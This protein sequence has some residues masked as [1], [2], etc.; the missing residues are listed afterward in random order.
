MTIPLATCCLY[1]YSLL[2]TYHCRTA[3]TLFAI[4]SRELLKSR[5][6]YNQS[7]FRS[8]EIVWAKSV[9][10]PQ[11]PQNNCMLM[12]RGLPPSGLHPVLLDP[13]LIGSWH[14][15]SPSSHR[16]THKQKWNLKIVPVLYVLQSLRVHIRYYLV[17]MSLRFR[18]CGAFLSLTLTLS[19]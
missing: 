6:K 8:S 1:P 10:L 11:P 18:R 14:K 3:V 5:I 13:S 9:C 4:T 19:V 15:L 17:C 16:K 2:W 7:Y 12:A